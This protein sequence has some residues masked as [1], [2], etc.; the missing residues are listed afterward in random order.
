[1]PRQNR[2]IM[3]VKDDPLMLRLR[4]YLV[5]DIENRM[6]FLLFEDPL[7]AAPAVVEEDGP[8]QHHATAFRLDT[9]SSHLQIYS[10]RM[11]IDTGSF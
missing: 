5:E 1:M 9:A 6:T 8:G 10:Y 7:L 2:E 3:A 11:W 4:L